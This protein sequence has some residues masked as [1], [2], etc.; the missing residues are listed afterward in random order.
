LN[1]RGSSHKPHGSRKE[2]NKNTPAG[3]SYIVSDEE[4]E[5]GDVIWPVTRTNE[6]KM[7]QK[8][9]QKNV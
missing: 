8:S 1:G 4:S 7:F 9:T 3:I 5:I 6:K 2:K